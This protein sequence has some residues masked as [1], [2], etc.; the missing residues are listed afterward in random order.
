LAGSG[1][2]PEMDLKYMYTQPSVNQH[3]NLFF[4]FYPTPQPS[5]R[6]GIQLVIL[7]PSFYCSQV[8]LQVYNNSCSTFKNTLSGSGPLVAQSSDTTLM[9]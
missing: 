9:K 5:N 3:S 4:D 7:P 8:A 1:A 2:R 6:Q